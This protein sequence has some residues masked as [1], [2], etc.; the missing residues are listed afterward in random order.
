MIICLSRWCF[1]AL[2]WCGLSKHI[3][4][5]LHRNIK[6][7]E[8]KRYEYQTFLRA[9]NKGTYKPNSIYVGD[10]S[11]ELVDEY[12]KWRREIKQNSDATH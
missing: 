9:T 7:G 12:I 10:I 6:T 3:T 4:L 11:G 5:F 1:M 2:I 8:K